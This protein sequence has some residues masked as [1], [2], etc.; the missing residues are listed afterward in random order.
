M[1]VQFFAGS[2]KLNLGQLSGLCCGPRPLPRAG[3]L[4]RQAFRRS[5][6]VMV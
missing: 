2:R 3:M 1:I 6:N 4:L 5:L